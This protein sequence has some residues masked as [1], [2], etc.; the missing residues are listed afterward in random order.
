MKFYSFSTGK[1]NK[2]GEL[3][4]GYVYVMNAYNNFCFNQMGYVEIK[5]CFSSISIVLLY[6]LE[7]VSR[8][9]YLNHLFHLS[10]VL[11]VILRGLPPETK[12]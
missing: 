9:R 3:K 10:K 6:Y 12:L 7:Q 1:Q 2:I 5:G 11:G 8:Y 4:L